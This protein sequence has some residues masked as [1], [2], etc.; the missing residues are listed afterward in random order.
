M[1]QD[2]GRWVDR[3]PSEGED[4]GAELMAGNGRRRKRARKRDVAL[5]C[6]IDAAALLLLLAAACGPDPCEDLPESLVHICEAL[7]DE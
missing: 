3:R 2:P 7:G 5:V 4:L 6:L 1:I